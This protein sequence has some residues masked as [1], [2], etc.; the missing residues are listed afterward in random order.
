LEERAARLGIRTAIAEAAG[1]LRDKLTE[2]AALVDLVL[3]PWEYVA[4]AESVRGLLVA[5]RPVLVGGWAVEGP[6]QLW[7]DART[8][9]DSG[10]SLFVATYLAERWQVPLT[11]AV[12]GQRDGA[13]IRAYLE[14]HELQ[15]VFATDG[16]P[17][18]VHD[19][20]VMVVEAW[21]QGLFGRRQLSSAAR[22]ALSQRAG[23]VILCP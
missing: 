23:T 19:R 20:L 15:T 14:L 8:G 13:E 21:E 12:S 4:I 11:V 22:G 10:S 5:G 1:T 3:V 2:R 6:V 7:L 17:D 16:E 9:S 18:E